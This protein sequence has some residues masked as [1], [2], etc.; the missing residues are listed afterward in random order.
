M[1]A[2]RTL[3]VIDIRGIQ[4]GQVVCIEAPT[5]VCAEGE[6]TSI[7]GRHNRGIV[8]DGK[9]YSTG[10]LTYY[11]VSGTPQPRSMPVIQL[12]DDGVRDTVTDLMEEHRWSSLPSAITQR[13]IASAA[14]GFDAS[15]GK[16]TARYGGKSESAWWNE[17]I[18]YASIRKS[19][20]RLV[21]DGKLVKVT[22]SSQFSKEK[23]DE[24]FVHIPG[25]TGWVTSEA[26]D[27]GV[28]KWS[29]EQNTKL[30]AELRRQASQTIAER[31]ADEVE[32]ELEL[33]KKENDL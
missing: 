19:L 14:L 21:N 24:R 2:S 3:T 28:E 22:R 33:L 15:V 30:M 12:T 17:F 9:S 23:G 25:K 7:G 29:S 31:H 20:D 10:R 16:P 6:V 5:G 8:V 27:E 13:D 11:L 32:A 1:D 4:V 18:K 26:Y